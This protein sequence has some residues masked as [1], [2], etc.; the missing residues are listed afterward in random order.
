[1]TLTF[2]PIKQRDNN[3]ELLRIV[4]M[5]MIVILHVVGHGHGI[6]NMLLITPDSPVDLPH[7]DLGLFLLTVI[8]VNTFVFISGYFGINFR[9]GSLL[10]LYA[11][12]VGIGIILF[13]INL[14]T[15][16]SFS[17][18]FLIKTLF[19][20]FSN[21]WWF[22]S[23]YVL[24][25]ILA[26][27]LNLGINQLSKKQ[28]TT[29]ILLLFLMNCF[30]GY[31]WMTFNA[32]NGY[33]IFNFM[34]LYLLARYMRKYDL[35][36][37]IKN[38]L[39]SYLGISCLLFLICIYLQLWGGRYIIKLTAYNNPLIIFSSVLF[40]K[41][42]QNM[43]IKRNLRLLSQ[44]MLGVYLIHD[45]EVMRPLIEKLS[46][47]FPSSLLGTLLIGGLIF[48]TSSLLEFFR[49][50]LYNK[51]GVSNLLNRISLKLW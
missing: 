36:R 39:L 44:L 11:Q 24:L 12:A 22:L 26:P 25:Y 50:C 31:L 32:N 49:I 51:L 6:T 35:F 3:I 48:C 34:F 40:F 8:S 41:V 45:N 30:G 14:F 33:S 38:P 28:Y 5:F 23:T 19:P 15:A 37:Y 42:F 43:N 17:L 1:M 20:V 13:V 47:I 29:I 27:F 4:L 2:S 21:Y 18:V 10:N 16:D 46:S 7:T 9:F